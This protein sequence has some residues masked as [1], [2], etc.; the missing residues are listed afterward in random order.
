MS[1]LRQARNQTEGAR[2]VAQSSS[3]CPWRP[4]K[5]HPC[6]T[7]PRHQ[8][9][10]RGAV[11][12]ADESRMTWSMAGVKASWRRRRA[13]SAA[14]PAP[15]RASSIAGQ[16]GARSR[17]SAPGRQCRRP[18]PRRVGCRARTARGPDSAV[19]GQPGRTDS[20]VLDR[21]AR[22]CSAASPRSRAELPVADDGAVDFGSEVYVHVIAAVRPRPTAPAGACDGRLSTA[23]W[24]HWP[25]PGRRRRAR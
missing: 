13:A 20:R 16:A 17:S 22:D 24:R 11:Q 21:S 10:L 3:A 1:G 4:E 19:P 5:E 9:R 15:D 6:P 23:P 7:A 2:W 14:H 25:A 18:R 8:T 12:R